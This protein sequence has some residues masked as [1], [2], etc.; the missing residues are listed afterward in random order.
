MGI[1]MLCNFDGIKILATLNYFLKKRNRQYSWEYSCVVSNHIIFLE[2]RYP[3]ES[4]T[5][6]RLRIIYSILLLVPNIYMLLSPIF[7]LSHSPNALQG[8]KIRPSPLLYHL[9][10]YKKIPDLK[11]HDHCTLLITFCIGLIKHKSESSLSH[12]FVM[13]HVIQRMFVGVRNHVTLTW[14]L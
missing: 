9:Y 4:E 6:L 1:E 12:Y 14:C 13:W 10:K 3:C 11:W 2:I 5:I 8:R 7:V